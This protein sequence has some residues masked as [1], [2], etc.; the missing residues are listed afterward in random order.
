MKRMTGKYKEKM[1]RVKECCGCK[2]CLPFNGNL[3][4][5][6]LDRTLNR[7]YTIPS[8]CPL[9]DVP[10][11]TPVTAAKPPCKTCG[12]AG[13]VEDD[14]D[15]MS[16]PEP[17][18]KSCPDC[19]A[20]TVN[21]DNVKILENGELSNIWMWPWNDDIYVVSQSDVQPYY[22]SH[23]EMKEKEIKWFFIKR[24][25]LKAIAKAADKCPKTAVSPTTQDTHLADKP[26]QQT[27][28]KVI[29][30]I[31]A[32]MKSRMD[33]IAELNLECGEGPGIAC[34][35]IWQMYH[36]LEWVLKILR[37]QKDEVV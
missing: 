31:D 25:T 29:G 30:M 19:R 17:S 12:G 27:N 14:D 37:E 7:P 32:R 13:R 24:E 18:Y 8:D 2:S 5:Y 16:G 6:K 20:K 3:V 9:E 28:E 34:S 10:E 15:D 11:P 23:R 21:E 26:Q 33:E 22:L 1:I 4:C 36:E 35:M